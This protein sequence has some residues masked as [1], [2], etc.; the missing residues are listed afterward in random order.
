MNY[1]IEQL[2]EKDWEAISK[3]YGEGIATGLATFEASVPSKEIW[4]DSHMK[5]CLLKL[6][7][8]EEET[9]G[10]A[11]LTSISNRCV[12]AGVAEVSVYVAKKAWGKGIGKTLLKELITQSEK[13]NI[14]TLQA[15]IFAENIASIKLHESVGF[16]IVGTREKLGKLNGKWHDV[17]LM[18]KRSEQI[19]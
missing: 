17:V 8:Q 12:Y 10:W 15:G 7:N 16:R 6:I 5:E 19:V 1:K 11:A 14:W 4:F 2:E 3:I 9:L 18:E 13:A